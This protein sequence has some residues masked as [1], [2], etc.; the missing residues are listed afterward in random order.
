MKK[1]I[2]VLLCFS[3]IYSCV[4]EKTSKQENNTSTDKSI[5]KEIIGFNVTSK[6]PDIGS[7]KGTDVSLKEMTTKNI[8][9]GEKILFKG[10]QF[11]LNNNIEEE[12]TLNFFSKKGKLICVAPSELSV[13]SMPPDGSGMTNYMQGDNIEISTMSLIKINSINFVI[14]EIKT[15]E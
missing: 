12:N 10:F 11:T 1:T 15:I 9:S 13:M 7:K 5:S 4:N 6:N 2:L 14:S 8:L 3:F